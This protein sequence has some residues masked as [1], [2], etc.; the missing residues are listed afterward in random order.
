MPD[1]EQHRSVPIRQN[2]KHGILLMLVGLFM[3]GVTDM[4]AKL[5]TDSLHPV[6][7]IW[8][9]Q[10]G[11]LVGVLFLLY[12]HGP[13]ILKTN[14]LLLQLGRGSL[15][16]CSALLFVFALR[17]VALAD[18]VAASFIAPFLVTLLGAAVLGEKIGVKRWSAIVIGFIGALIIVRPGLGVIHPAVMLVILAAFFYALRQVVGR[19]LADSDPTITTIT[20]TALAGSVV[21]SIPLLFVWQWPPS[22][23]IWLILASLAI[24]GALGEIFIIKALEVTEASVLAPT[25]YTLI[26]WAT[27]YGYLVFGQLP[28]GWT[29]LGTGIIVTAGLYAWHRHRRLATT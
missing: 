14:N 19:L 26:I 1:S 9:R 20:Y 5:L 25:H 29:L 11:L 17:Y 13:A 21:I 15:A 18:A 16:I 12:W 27:L 10:I 4:Q 7:I 2:S 22:L 24:T 28:D 6:Q 3:F 8:F 23:T